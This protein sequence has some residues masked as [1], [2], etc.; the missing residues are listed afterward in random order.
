MIVNRYGVLYLYYC[1][2]PYWILL[3]WISAGVII[4]AEKRIPN[5]RLMSHRNFMLDRR[6]TSL[7]S[8]TQHPRRNL[9]TRQPF[10]IHRNN[11][12][13]HRGQHHNNPNLKS[14]QNDYPPWTMLDVVLS[15]LPEIGE[16]HF[17]INDIHSN[18]HDNDLNQPGIYLFFQCTVPL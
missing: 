15:K 6:P 1:W 16:V 8:Y 17:K 2:L 13:N 9:P 10:G 18:H 3:N 11:Y 14:A 12:Q 7:N 5:N 4:N